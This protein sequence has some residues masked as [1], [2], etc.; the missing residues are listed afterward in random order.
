M[1][2][3]LMV[4]MMLVV[5]AVFSFT[6]VVAAKG[7]APLNPE[8]T[9]LQNEYV[10]DI[11][12]TYAADTLNLVAADIESRLDAGETLAEIAFSAGVED[13]Y[14]FMQDAR[15]FVSEELAAQGIVIPGWDN[16]RQ[17]GYQAGNAQMQAYQT[18]NA[19]MQ[20]YQGA[21]AQMQAYQAENAQDGTCLTTGEPLNGT[22]TP[23]GSAY[24][25]GR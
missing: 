12:I 9:T 7:P 16:A 19:Q 4:S 1:N 14:A 15:I 24:R 18:G 3:K 10:H 20:A 22:G 8:T 6:G 5:V 25:G 21:N 11:L 2:K 13:Y 17:Q 23:M